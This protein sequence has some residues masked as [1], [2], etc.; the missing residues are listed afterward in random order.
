MQHAVSPTNSRLALER[1]T[2]LTLIDNTPKGRGVFASQ[3]IPARTVIE[4]CPVLILDPAEVKEHIG[5]AR[6][7]RGRE[8]W[9]TSASYTRHSEMSRLVRSCAF[10]TA[11]GDCGLRMRR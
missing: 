6:T 8:M 7:W 9:R 2:G 10:L 3:P 4:V 1:V 5:T 11:M